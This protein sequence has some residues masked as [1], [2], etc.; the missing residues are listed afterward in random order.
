M[1][2]VSRKIYHFGIFLFLTLAF[3]VVGAQ[4]II[5]VTDIDYR[6]LPNGCVQFFP[7]KGDMPLTEIDKWKHLFEWTFGDDDYSLEAEPIR[8]FEQ[9]CPLE[10]V[11][12][13]VTGIKIEADPERFTSESAIL[14]DA[15]SV[16]IQECRINCS[17]TTFS[18]RCPETHGRNSWTQTHFTAGF[19]PFGRPAVSKDSIKVPVYLLNPSPTDTLLVDVLITATS[20]SGA[21][22]PL[23]CYKG[24][25]D[26]SECG[27]Y[28]N[29]LLYQKVE[30]APRE[31]VI[32]LGRAWVG[33]EIKAMDTIFWEVKVVKRGEESITVQN[34]Q[35]LPSRTEFSNVLAEGNAKV[36]VESSID[37]NHKYVMN[38]RVFRPG[39]RVDYRITFKN[40]GNASE[41]IVYIWDRLSEAFDLNSLREI[42]ATMN[43]Y[44]LDTI[45]PTGEGMQCGSGIQTFPAGFPSTLTYCRDGRAI[46]FQFMAN[47]GRASLQPGNMGTIDFSINLNKELPEF[48]GDTVDCENP[49]P[50]IDQ[51]CKCKVVPNYAISWFSGESKGYIAENGEMVKVVMECQDPPK[52]CKGLFCRKWIIILLAFVP[53]IP[54]MIVLIRRLRNR[55][56]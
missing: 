34:N 49:S 2:Q 35:S 24:K 15:P 1:K 37:P 6:E 19:D 18:Q 56:R 10:Q 29:K 42:R 9:G 45:H 33:E 28:Q 21:M 41:R 55:P 27:R 12:L 51:P 8:C 36:P 30:I 48:V 32:L 13:R 46:Q 52:E 14:A 44:P 5:L 26:Q 53:V 39:D 23:S 3:Q 43:G 7:K 31:K 16:I 50:K 17:V 40:T 47:D 38:G 54:I 22:V 20:K 4:S 25:T 11:S